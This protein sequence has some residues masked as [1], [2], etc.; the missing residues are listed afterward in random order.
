M[1][2]SENGPERLYDRAEYIKS[3][4]AQVVCVKE[5]D[6]GYLV[7]LDRTGFYPEGGG[8]LCDFGTLGGLPV[9][10]VR[11]KDGQIWHRV[12][13]AFTQGDRVEGV[14]DW[15][16]RLLMMQQHTGEH[17][18]SGIV[19]RRYG[20]E[21]VGF[22]MGSDGV[23]VDFDGEIPAGELSALEWETNR[24]IWENIPV[25]V[26]YPSPQALQQLSYRSKK[27]LTGPVRIVTIAG[28]DVCAC[29]G[30]HLHS[31][32]EVGMVKILSCQKHKG[33]VRLTLLMGQRAM[34][35]YRQLLGSVAGISALLSAKQEEVLEA[36]QRLSQENTVL[37]QQQLSDL[38][39]ESFC[40][41]LDAIAPQKVIC[42][43]ESPG[44]TPVQL[45]QF[46]LM[47]CEKAQ[48]A[49]V[50][51]G[52]DGAGYKYALG[53]SVLDV[54]EMG[55]QL[56]QSLQGRG[57]GARDLIQGSVN[58]RAEEIRRYFAELSEQGRDGQ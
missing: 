54:R 41:R 23:T 34:L 21:N 46:C 35:H 2:I 50:F 28:Y 3:F 9:T 33:G 20:F 48:T 56:N 49:A 40:R 25:Q 37:L 6:K 31:T 24:A 44:L 47:A 36:V 8:Q 57:G 17:L 1:E 52:E 18:L 42:L 15:D 45:R 22:H 10:D 27:A 16:R 39:K 19:H 53:S 58:A 51:S 30:T 38:R 13:Q 29:C 55:K 12:P 26:E 14:I 4:T 32:G 5:D 11:E 43:L 7:A